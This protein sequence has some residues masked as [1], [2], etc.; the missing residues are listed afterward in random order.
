M[1]RGKAANAVALHHGPWCKATALAPD[2]SIYKSMCS[3]SLGALWTLKVIKFEILFIADD[4][5]MY[6]KST[7]ISEYG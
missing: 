2:N 5:V 1:A 4:I 7:I 3:H 6:I